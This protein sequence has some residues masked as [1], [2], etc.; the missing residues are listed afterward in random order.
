MNFGFKGLINHRKFN[1]LTYNISS[2]FII[3]LK[4]KTKLFMIS[5]GVAYTSKF[6]TI[7]MSV[8]LM[9]PEDGDA[10]K[11][12]ETTWHHNSDDRNRQKLIRITFIYEVLPKSSGNLPIKKN[13]LS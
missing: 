10:S 1:Y 4:S 13:C 7:V 2:V 9:V 11:M 6:Q 12:L 8:V 3:K 5:S